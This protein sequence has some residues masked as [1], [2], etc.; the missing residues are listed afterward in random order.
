MALFKFSTLDPVHALLTLQDEL[1]RVF[2]TSQIDPNVSVSGR[3]VYP[4]I[5]VFRNPNGMTVKVEVPGLSADALHV[6][7]HGRTLTVKGKRAVVAP[8]GA[9][10]HRRERGRGEFSRSIQMPADCDLGRTEAAYR[11]GILTIR[12]PQREEAKPR[13]IAVAAS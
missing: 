8:E 10:F 11:Q 5:N 6:E 12:I 2:G 7:A 13:Q 1:D 3:G 9:A 4:P